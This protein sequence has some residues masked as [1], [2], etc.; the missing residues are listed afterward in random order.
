EHERSKTLSIWMIAEDCLV[1]VPSA[2]SRPLN[3]TR[4]QSVRRVGGLHGGPPQEAGVRCG[5]V[6]GRVFTGEAR[7]LPLDD[8]DD[9]IV[10]EA[11]DPREDDVGRLLQ[12]GFEFGLVDDA[13]GRWMWLEDGGQMSVSM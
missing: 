8:R 4:N 6:E 9:K 11:G 12:A 2:V 1:A 10:A 5:E 13:N 7:D 3:L